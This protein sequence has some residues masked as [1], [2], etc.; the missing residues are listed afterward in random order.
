VTGYHNDT[1]PVTEGEDTPS[2]TEFAA[3]R[4]ILPNNI[5]EGTTQGSEVVILLNALEHI[6]ELKWHNQ[7]L[8]QENIALGLVRI[9][10][11]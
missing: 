5:G 10:Y 6:Q 2:D 11:A 7:R 8:R 9:I 1:I 3:L 4:E